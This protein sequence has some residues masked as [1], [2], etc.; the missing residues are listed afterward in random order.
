MSPWIAA[1]IWLR[2]VVGATIDSATLLNVTSPRLNS[3]GSFL[4]SARAASWAAARRVGATSVASI[5]PDVSVT[6]ITAPWRCGAATVRSGRPSAI[7]SASS[8]SIAKA[9]GMCRPHDRPATAAST[10]TFV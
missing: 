8:A 4:V 10:S 9:A 5:E 3:S 7:S 1:K 6:M 2:S